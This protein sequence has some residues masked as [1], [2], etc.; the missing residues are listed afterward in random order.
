MRIVREGALVAATSVKKVATTAPLF[1]P[2]LA[3]SRK[4]SRAMDRMRPVA[5]LK[6]Q[7]EADL[8]N[9][10]HVLLHLALTGQ[11]RFIGSAWVIPNQRVR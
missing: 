1:T 10:P 8:I 11:T 7:V 3:V 9:P 5:R 6:R 4:R 2:S